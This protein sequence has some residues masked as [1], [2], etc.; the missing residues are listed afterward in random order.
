MVKKGPDR[1]SH[2]NLRKVLTSNT[3]LKGKL[4]ICLIVYKGLGKSW[5]SQNEQRM[6]CKVVVELSGGYI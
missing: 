1:V 2:T 3:Y 5:T 4:Q 6:Y